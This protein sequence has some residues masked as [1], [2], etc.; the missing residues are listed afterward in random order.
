[1]GSYIAQKLGALVWVLGGISVI[2]FLVLRLTPGDPALILL[3]PIATQEDVTQLRA[4]MGLNEPLYVQY[5]VWLGHVLRGD[6]GRSITMHRPVLP[7]VLLKLRATAL[8]TGAALLFSTTTGIAAGVL[9]GWKRN[10][11]IDRVSMVIA[12][13]G[14]SIPVFWLGIVLIFV[15]SVWLRVLPAGGMHAPF[16]GGSLDTLAHLILPALALGAASA[17]IV[18][19]I[20]RSS[21]LEVIRQD[22]MR[23]ARAKGVA[24]GKVLRRHGL[25]NALIPVITVIGVQVGFLLSGAILTET[26]FSWPGVGTMLVTAILSRDFPTV[27]G[28]VLFVATLFVLVNLAV[29]ISYTYLDPR[30]RYE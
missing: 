2:V 10:S 9:A 23:T 25:K 24:E 5:A 17:G 27:Q 21:M 8:L 15:F 11:V 16:G 26:V 1:V 4:E 7:E 14:V 19:R 3:G 18:A 13:L 20:T 6:L 30:I 28:G 29:D 12:L 22:Y